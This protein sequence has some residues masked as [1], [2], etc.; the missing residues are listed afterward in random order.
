MTEVQNILK[1]HG[2]KVQ[3][4]NEEKI[5]EHYPFKKRSAIYTEE[6]DAIRF[7]SYDDLRW[8]SPY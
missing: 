8:F 3:Y 4:G 5:G 1:K 6:D 2:F 7:D